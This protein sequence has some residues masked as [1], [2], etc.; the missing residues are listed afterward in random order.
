MPLPLRAV[1]RSLAA[2]AALAPVALR[3]Q[4]PAPP[5][6][7][8][9]ALG[10]IVLPMGAVSGEYERAL[11]GGLAAG[12][13]GTAAFGDNFVLGSADERYASAQA[14][15]KY[16]PSRGGL[17]GF[18]VGATAGVVH[19]RGVPSGVVYAPCPMPGCGNLDLRRT[20]TAPT[21]GVIADYNLVVGRRVLVGLGLGVRRVVGSRA[22]REVVGGTLPDGRLV[23]GYG[24]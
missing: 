6:R 14:K 19:G 9:V 7:Q 20:A 13:G 15:L 23:V 12:V 17:R 10:P 5:P 2:A 24:F 8:A 11:G 16:Y 21:V 18:A 22:D 4:A 1:A 3:A